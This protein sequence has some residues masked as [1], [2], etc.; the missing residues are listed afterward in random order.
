MAVLQRWLEA[1]VRGVSWGTYRCEKWGKKQASLHSEGRA[2]DW[3]VD[4][5]RRRRPPRR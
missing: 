1:N 2:I 3:H 5:M 4:A